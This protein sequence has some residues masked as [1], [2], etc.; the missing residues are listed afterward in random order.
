MKMDDVVNKE[1]F[2]KH[3]NMCNMYNITRPRCDD[4]ESSKAAIQSLSHLST[5]QQTA[6]PQNQLIRSAGCIFP[7]AVYTTKRQTPL[8]FQASSCGLRVAVCVLFET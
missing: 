3:H 8:M 5:W 1:A 2:I 6:V 4:N 7:E